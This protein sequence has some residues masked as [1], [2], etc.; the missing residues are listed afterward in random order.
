MI[1]ES[2]L[3]FDDAFKSNEL[4]SFS[5]LLFFSFSFEILNSLHFLQNSHFFSLSLLLL[6]FYFPHNLFSFSNLGNFSLFFL[7]SFLE[8]SKLII[9]NSWVKVFW[10]YNKLRCLM[11]IFEREAIFFSKYHLVAHLR[12]SLQIISICQRVHIL[13]RR[14]ISLFSFD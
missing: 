7:R 14:A 5:F 4:I 8:L 13:W 2:S 1:S 9:L 3:N 10:G 6:L 11:T 12:F